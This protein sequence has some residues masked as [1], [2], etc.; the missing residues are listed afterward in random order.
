MKAKKQL[1]NLVCWAG[2]AVLCAIY[3]LP[4]YVVVV[5]SLKP[6]TDLSSRLAPPSTLYLDNYLNV[7]K[8]G[9][10][11]NAIKNNVIII[12]GALL[13]I[14]VAGSL[15]AY[16]IARMR[17]RWNEGVR[18]LFMGIMMITPLTILVGLYSIL[19]RINAI[20]TYWGIILVLS[21]FGVPMSVYLYSNFISTIPI[22]LDE[23]AAIDGAGRLQTFF[24]VI[25]P[26]LAPVTVTVIIMQGVSIWN[27][28]LF[29]HY[30]LQRRQM[31]TVTQV[32]QGFFSTTS[33]DYG[34]AAAVA[35]LGML[36]VVVLYLFLQKYF[37]KGAI[38]S[39]VK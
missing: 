17:S 32:I 9:E 30:I 4:F 24:L 13:V 21:T 37:V 34:G 16:P 6:R 28:Y 23:A 27:N 12:A 19:S 8:S 36:P 31:F 26:Q 14:I 33:S 2:S 25:L 39:A 7:L 3:L 18:K 1:R 29:T 38:D 35:I 5:L 11:L 22:E 20:S 15:A 10:I